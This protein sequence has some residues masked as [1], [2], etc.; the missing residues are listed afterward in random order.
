M[1]AYGL[2]PERENR[3]ADESEMDQINIVVTNQ[4]CTLPPLP[5]S[6]SLIR[7]YQLTDQCLP[8][9]TISFL[10]QPVVRSKVTLKHIGMDAFA[11]SMS[12]LYNSSDI[13]VPIRL[14]PKPLW[15]LLLKFIRRVTGSVQRIRW[16]SWATQCYLN[17]SHD[18]TCSGPMAWICRYP[19][20]YNVQCNERGQL[21][22]MSLRGLQLMGSTDLLH[23]PA[24]V[25]VLDIADNNLIS[26]GLG[27]LRGK[28][29]EYLMA[30]NN[31]IS[32]LGFYGLFGSQLKRLDVRGNPCLIELNALGKLLENEN[33][34]IPLE[35]MSVSYAQL[36]WKAPGRR[37]WRLINAND[38]R[39][40]ADASSLKSFLVDG[41]ETKRNP[42][43]LKI[44]MMTV[45]P[46]G[47]F[48]SG[49]RPVVVVDS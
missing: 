21:I 37:R 49:K 19:S 31:I 25:R 3:N 27:S 7:L 47:H 6:T 28:A 12:E 24:T 39:P 11:R 1:S 44:S 8:D 48:D 35:T 4:N 16:F 23:L 2:D 13:R 18:E 42:H 14:Q 41:L 33:A 10:G 38:I 9:S 40:W 20:E 22:S 26:M 32:R 43:L 17:S 5:P 34:S 46:S 29:L 15:L 45:E 36:R 30:E